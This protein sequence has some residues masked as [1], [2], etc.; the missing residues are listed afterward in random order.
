M[1]KNEQGVI[2]VVMCSVCNR[3]FQSCQLDTLRR[4]AAGERHQDKMK[5]YEE[6]RLAKQS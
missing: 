1:E 5:Q 4:H 2:S 3:S 6:G